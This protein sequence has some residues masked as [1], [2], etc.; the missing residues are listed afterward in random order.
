MAVYKIFPSQ[1]TTLYSAYPIMNTGLNAICEISNTLGLSLSP[2]V[3]RYIS[4]FDNDEIQD[5]INNKISGSSYDVFLR[6]FIAE[7]QGINEDVSLEILP[8]AQ[9]W[10][11]G[12]GYYLDNPQ[13]TDGASWSAANFSG[14]GNWS[15]SG[16]IGGFAYTGS[17]NSGNSI[18]GG[19]NWFIT[20]SF[21]VIQSFGLRS[22]KDIETNVSD[23]VNAWYS[24]SIPN[25]GFIFKLSSSFEFNPSID[26]QP[27]LKYY[28]VDT[29]TIYPPCL[30]FRWF[31]YNTVLTGS[32][33][34]SIVTTSNLKMSL[35]ENPGTF[36]PESINRFYIN[37]SPL[38]P[39]R[40][41]QTASLYTNLNY[42]PT[43]SYYA[44]KDL[45]TN[46]FV[47]N[48][49]DQYTQISSND[50]GNYFDVYMSGL[51]PERYYKILVKTLINGST[52]IFDDN[53][54]F[55]VING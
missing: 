7:A 50:K 44:I 34:S 4:Q 2:G 36:F 30:E 42:L 18:K 11:N 12:T 54:Y 8:L 43:S 45:A 40:V 46:E 17:D 47:V 53:Y 26:I 23:T 28:S 41:Y 21:L 10:N 24:S 48:F 3:S 6:N 49:D 39:T 35:A 19:G 15:M 31:D 22:V 13:V 52:L 33:T 9:S 55:K 32:A 51:E 27:I 16:S 25:Y 38:Y 1:D 5:I 20:S 14:S 37:V 29:N